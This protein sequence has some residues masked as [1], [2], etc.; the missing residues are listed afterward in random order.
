MNESRYSIPVSASDRSVRGDSRMRGDVCDKE[1]GEGG[2]V[3]ASG[4]NSCLK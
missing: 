1:E 4:R 3:S 2:E